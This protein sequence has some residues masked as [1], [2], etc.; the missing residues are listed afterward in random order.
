[1]TSNASKGRALITGASSGIGKELAQIFAKNGHDLVLVARSKDKLDQLAGTLSQDFDIETD[2]IVQDLAK[3]TGPKVLYKSVQDLGKPI[4]VLV[5]NAGVVSVGPYADKPTDE[6]TKLVSLNV[7]AVSDLVSRFLPE[8]IERRKGRILNVASIASFQPIPTMAVYSASKAFV[9]S[10][11]ESLSEELRGTGV[12]V[13]A[14]CPGL[15]K[16]DM[17]DQVQDAYEQ[18][19]MIPSFLLSDAGDVA[20]QGYDAC[21]SGRVIQVPGIAN[22]LTTAWVQA[23]PRWLVRSVGGFF[24][25]QMDWS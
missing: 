13:S 3:T 25:R 12:T 20:Q 4:D 18:A 14:L 16:T 1:M 8:M 24:S 10:L 22:Q 5:N 6:I 9:L 19:Q 11:T 17:V 2:V 23:Q 15:T 7:L 21:M